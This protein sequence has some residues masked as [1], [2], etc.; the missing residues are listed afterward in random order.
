M[1]GFAVKVM[2]LKLRSPSLA[3]AS[4]KTLGAERIVAELSVIKKV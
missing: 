1:G 2:Q 4:Y 3:R